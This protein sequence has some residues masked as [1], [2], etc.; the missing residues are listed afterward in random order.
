[1][2]YFFLLLFL[3]MLSCAKAEIDD[4]FIH[5][6][7]KISSLSDS[8]IKS[9]LAG[10]TVE[11][12]GN[13]YV[14]AFRDITTV[15]AD[16]YRILRALEQCSL[17]FCTYEISLSDQGDPKKLKNIKALDKISIKRAS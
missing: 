9:L 11:L 3:S 10:Q 1:M 7:P 6:C 17:S 13:Q 5:V 12:D 15:N 8:K 14:M 16:H 4:K 2:H